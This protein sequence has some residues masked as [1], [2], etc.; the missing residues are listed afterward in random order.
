MKL[1]NFAIVNFTMMF[2]KY[3]VSFFV[4]FFSFHIA[5]GQNSNAFK[6][7]TIVID[8]GHGGKD[9][10]AIGKK[11]KE[12][13]LTLAVALLL[14]EKVER[15]LKNIKVIYTRKDDRFVELFERANIANRS[16][17][18]LFISIH[19]NSAKSPEA[20]GT[21]AWVLGLHRSDENLNLAKR[22][23]AV[24]EFEGNIEQN[25][26][27]DP[28]SPTGNIIITM[29]QSAFLNQ[30]I[31]FAKYVERQFVEKVDRQNRG[32]HQAGFI[33]LYK[34]V[35]PSCLIELGFISN[36]EEEYYMSSPEG[37][38]EISNSIFKALKQFI[39]DYDESLGK[40]SSVE[41]ED[42]EPVAPKP[43]TPVRVSSE[44]VDQS[45][46]P[47]QTL[48]KSNGEKPMRTISIEEE[49]EAPAPV[50]EKTSSTQKK[51]EPASE[52]EETFKEAFNNVI[53]NT[54][55]AEETRPKEKSIE[56]PVTDKKTIEKPIEKKLV[57]K[58]IEK[59]PIEKPIEKKPVEKPIEKPIVKSTEKPIEKP[60]EKNT[61]KSS[62]GSGIEY[63]V[64]VKANPT[65]ISTKDP[66]FRLNQDV[67]AVVEN[68]V[69]KYQCGNFTDKNEAK[70]RLAKAIKD[71]FKDAFI[72]VYENGVKVV[73]G[74][75]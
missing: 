3:K 70:A 31:Q 75:K 6:I 51:K 8:P 73:P 9:P 23:N 40:K 25:Y 71:G 4:L 47:K 55:S 12:K 33:V 30:S 74:K 35:M 53:N 39:R 24:L 7:N 61:A 59:K 49:E 15:S 67:I 5:V 69:Y 19:I 27:F 36:R 32:V 60:L 50:K 65:D 63:R 66:L 22:E 29:Q 56:K 57:E 45:E 14:G 43:R 37:Q 38:E 28:N 18:D 62:A 1:L 42:E 44:Q 41:P 17:A 21:E 72:V 64:Q 11:S 68:G 26:G 2:R 34:T 16:K 54:P 46:R 20:H 10:G 48:S 13:D 52:D 58:P